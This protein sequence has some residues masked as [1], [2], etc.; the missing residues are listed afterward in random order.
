M[1]MVHFKSAAMI[2][3][4]SSVLQCYIAMSLHRQGMHDR[5]LAKLQE[6]ITLDPK[7]PLAR[8]ERSSVL[9]DLEMHEEALAE[10]QVGQWNE[11]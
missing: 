4:T 2:N 9:M 1:A 7:N 8:F 11:R 3:P 10:L 6:A 5:A